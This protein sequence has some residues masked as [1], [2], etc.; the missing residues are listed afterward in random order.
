MLGVTSNHLV[1]TVRQ[2][3]NK[4][5]GRILQDRLMLEAKR[6]LIYTTNSITEIAFA[7]SFP[8]PAQFGRW[9]KKETGCSPGQFRKQ[10][11]LFA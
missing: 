10:F 2:K 4:T 9:F 3:T 6:L 11:V 1:Q 5:P 7:L 8:N